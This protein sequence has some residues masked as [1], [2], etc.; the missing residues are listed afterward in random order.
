MLVLLTKKK[1]KTAKRKKISQETES[2]ADG[3]M[4]SSRNSQN[5]RR[6]PSEDP[7]FGR[8]FREEK[9]L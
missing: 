1:K 9:V 4:V 5:I 8:S 2:S 7:D 3:A 6:P